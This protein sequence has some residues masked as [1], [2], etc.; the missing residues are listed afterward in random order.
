VTLGQ[1]RRDDWVLIIGTGGVAVFALQ[2]AVAL[3][4]KVVVLSSSDAKL[5]HARALGAAVTINYREVPDWDAAVKKATGG[6][7]QHVI[8]LGGVGTLARS[9]A[10]A[11]VGG[12]IALIGALDGF[13]GDIS[14]VAL[15]TAALRVS[16][17]VVGSHADHVALQDLFVAH[18]LRPVIDHVFDA[19]DAEAAYARAAAG[20]FGKVVIRMN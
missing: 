7:V 13:G 11:A 2:I 6:G 15:I 14:G 18:K 3:G 19:S 17:V 4:A 16:A 10:S 8:E 12:H 1:V 9:L 20:A 5:D